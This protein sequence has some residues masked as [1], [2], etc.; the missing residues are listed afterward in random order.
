M[1]LDPAAVHIDAADFERLA[2][3][4][5]AGDL[6]QSIA[7]YRGALPEGI[8]LVALAPDGYFLQWRTRLHDLALHVIGTLVAQY[9][10]DGLVESALRTTRRGLVLDPFDERLFGH[11]IDLLQR[12]G[13]HPSRSHEIRV[14]RPARVTGRGRRR[15]A[16]GGASPVR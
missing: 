9:C 15:P 14:R 10:R 5:V 13:R 7:L 8:D 4:G 2:M 16:P 3:S 12:L 1:R 6:E 11:L